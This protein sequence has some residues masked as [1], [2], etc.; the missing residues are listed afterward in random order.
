M[1]AGR[2]LPKIKEGG[3]KW[4]GSGYFDGFWRLPYSSV[5]KKIKF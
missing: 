5:G 4:A 3:L 2:D 1:V